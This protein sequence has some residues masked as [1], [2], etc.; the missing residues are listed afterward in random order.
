MVPVMPELTVVSELCVGKVSSQMLLDDGAI[1]GD[2][3]TQQHNWLEIP[4]ISML[5]E[6]ASEF[7]TQTYLHAEMHAGFYVKCPL[8]LS[9]FNKNWNVSLNI[10]TTSQYKVNE[11]PFNCL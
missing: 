5:L 11:N 1:T 4:H 8:L 10:Y 9:A 7:L 3:H 2:F 6:V